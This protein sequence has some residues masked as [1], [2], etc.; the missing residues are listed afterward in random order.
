MPELKKLLVDIDSDFF[1]KIFEYSQSNGIKTINILN[2]NYP[3]RLKNIYDYP[4]LLFAKGNLDILNSEKIIAIV[5]TRNCSL[6]GN[7]I[8]KEFSYSLAK[9]GAIIVSGI[10]KGIDTQAHIGALEAS[11]KTI[12]VLGSGINYVYPKENEKLYR[13]II[14]KSGLVISEYPL[15]TK[16]IPN[17]FPW[18]NRIISGLSDKVLVTEASKK[19]GSI[20]TANFALEQGREV[21]AIPGNIN[22]IV[23]KGTNDL[24]KDGANLVSCI[25]DIWDL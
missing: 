20:I 4:I 11:G 19:S 21:Y 15:Y 13:S 23:S 24:I 8:T 10:A 7:K 12:A 1:E 3:E 17:Y 16:P 14:E 9:R 25:E 2:K 5:G 6:Y 18:R 22:S